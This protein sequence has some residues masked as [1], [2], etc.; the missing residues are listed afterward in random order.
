MNEEKRLNSLFLQPRLFR[1]ATMA[2]IVISVAS[3]S[4]CL[5]PKC[6]LSE[7]PQCTHHQYKSCTAMC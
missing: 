5:T 3:S 2:L 7:V 6:V 4:P 1:P